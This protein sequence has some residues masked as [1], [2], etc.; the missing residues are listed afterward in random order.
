MRNETK[1][2]FLCQTVDAST[3]LCSA[4]TY[5]V[6]E[7]GVEYGLEVV[8]RTGDSA[9]HFR[10]GRPLPKNLGQLLFTNL[11]GREQHARTS[12]SLSASLY[13]NAYWLLHAN[14]LTPGSKV[15]RIAPNCC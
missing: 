4:Q 15:R 5:C 7:D 9:Q 1:A 8:R 10:D 14:A 11:N 12:I 2:S 3:F 6:V 13:C